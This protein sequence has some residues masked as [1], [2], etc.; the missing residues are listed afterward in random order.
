MPVK[1]SPIKILSDLGYEMVDIET[2]ADYLSALKEAIATIE[3]RTGGRGDERSA[4]LREE[5]I[6]LRRPK[7]KSDVVLEGLASFFA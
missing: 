7:V 1:I 3:F 5:V 4:A 6:K 2:D